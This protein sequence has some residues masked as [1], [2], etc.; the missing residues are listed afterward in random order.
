[1]GF[2]KNDGI[3]DNSR[4]ESKINEVIKDYFKPEF[5]NRLDHVVV[6]RS[7]LHEDML[8]IVDMLL[9]KVN[10]RM[11][12]INLKV[13]VSDDAKAWLADRGCDKNLGARP[14]RRLIST[15]IEDPI[16]ELILE[17]RMLSGQEALVTVH[18]DGSKLTATV[19]ETDSSVLEN[20]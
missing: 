6:F 18:A 4:I 12:A 2:S 8:T 7:L 17:A 20:L 16:S 15:E 13:T 3:A 19:V 1:M 9:A 14:L 5:L 10:E 11:Y